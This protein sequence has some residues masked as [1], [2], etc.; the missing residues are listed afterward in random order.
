MNIKFSENSTIWSL[1]Y[2]NDADEDGYT[3]EYSGLKVNHD[4]IA[5]LP[6]EIKTIIAYYS[7]FVPLH[8]FLKEICKTNDII[9]ANALGNFSTLEEAQR[10]LLENKKGTF[11]KINFSNKKY[12]N[13]LNIKIIDNEITCEYSLEEIYHTHSGTNEIK[14]D[15]FIKNNNGIIE[16]IK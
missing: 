14:V 15:R 13:I 9:L 16:Y 10:I 4:F 1:G 8:E 3:Y 2:S 7:T 12:P 11:E 6:V 5:G